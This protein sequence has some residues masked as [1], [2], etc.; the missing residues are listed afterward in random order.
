MIGSL[1]IPASTSAVVV[2]SSRSPITVSV[3]LPAVL[4][5]TA[6]V[7]ASPGLYSG[8]SSAISSRSGVSAVASAYQ[9]ESKLTDVSGPCGSALVT[10]SR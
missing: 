6:T 7:M 3:T 9:P 1:A 5:V 2:V 10:C 8:L 4:A